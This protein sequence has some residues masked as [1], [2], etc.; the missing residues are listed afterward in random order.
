MSANSRRLAAKE[1]EQRRQDA[2]FQSNVRQVEIYSKIPA[3]KEISLQ[4][5]NTTNE[6]S[7]VI[8]SN[9]ADRKEKLE[10]IMRD[11]LNKQNEI[12][13]L[14]VQNGY[15]DNY[16]DVNYSCPICEDSGYV[17]GVKCECLKR[18]ICKYNVEE[19]NADT[20]IMP[21][22]RFDNFSLKYY[23]D[24]NS[25]GKSPRE[26]MGDIL[27]NCREYA[28]RFS[29]NAKSI[30]MIG[31][32]GLGKTHLSAAIAHRVMEKGYSVLYGS[33]PDL[34]RK[35]Q[36]EY[37]GRGDEGVDTMDM[38]QKADLVIIDDL[39]AE[40]EGQ[41]YSSAFYNIINRR[42]NMQ[43]PTIISTNLTLKEIEARYSDR[44]A[45][46]LMTMYRCLKFAGKDIRQLKLREN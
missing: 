39:G 18:L 40:I 34:F 19:F 38:L 16:L 45:S 43:K 7:A 17:N 46:R 8:F 31:G 23:S 42:L 37:Y 13:K 4:L 41:F 28:E 27:N 33:A 6:I 15:P 29:P 11:N 14:L 12:K 25:G 36:S 35:L 10:R 30:L 26:I 24:S 2:I 1:I 22:A 44:V 3:V 5:S 9:A 21:D 32:T 20:A